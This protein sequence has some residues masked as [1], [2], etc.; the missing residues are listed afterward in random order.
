VGHLILVDGL[1]P[2]RE[3]F[4]FIVDHVVANEPQLIQAASKKMAAHT[5][6]KSGYQNLKS[7]HDVL[8]ADDFG[9]K[10][11]RAQINDTNMFGRKIILFH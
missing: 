6:N 8:D 11:R 9:L 5:L 10:Y 4:T 3:Q 1:L 7:F 2:A